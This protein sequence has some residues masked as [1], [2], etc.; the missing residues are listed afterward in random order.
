[1]LYLDYI[2]S[3]SGGD[4]IVLQDYTTMGNWIKDIMSLAVSFLTTSH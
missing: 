1:M 2:E 4:I 3:I